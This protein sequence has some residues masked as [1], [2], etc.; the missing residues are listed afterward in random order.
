MARLP[1][2]DPADLAPEDRPLLV[3][4]VNLYRA[5]V[6]SPGMT[7][8]FLGLAHHIRHTSVLD[9]RLRELAILQM[10][11]TA[12]S[13][14]EWSH[15]V[16]ISRDFGVTDADIAAIAVESR[17]EASSLEPA[18]RVVLR[19][20]REMAAGDLSAEGFA[21]LEEHLDAVSVTDLLVIIAFYAG[22]VRFLAAARIDVEPEYQ[23]HLD[24]FPLPAD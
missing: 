6:N 17:G 8:A 22:V 10:G 12:R 3:R 13:P 9:G 23:R 4:P 1:Y 20:A 24:Q 15:H 7:R 14:Y 5:M 19:A 2:L 21:A 18:A 16:A 11:W